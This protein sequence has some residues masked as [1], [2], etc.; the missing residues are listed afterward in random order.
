VTDSDRPS[1]GPDPAPASAPYFKDFPPSAGTH[2]ASGA[3]I[4][5]LED[6]PRY[7]IA[8]GV[9]FCPVFGR[10]M[11]LNFVAFPPRS[12][13][14]THVHPEEQISI[15]REGTMEITVGEVSRWV[16]PGDVIVFPSGVPHSGRTLDQPCRLIDIFSP[17]RE[18]LREVIAAA[19][20]V[21]S[22]DVDRWWSPGSEPDP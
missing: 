6:Y 10:N 14:P 7:E 20:P 15:V 18:G 13:F 5:N 2:D 11:S 8:Q 21:R 4:V 9:V 3:S 12:G 19:D 16:V 22:A 17:P 1:D